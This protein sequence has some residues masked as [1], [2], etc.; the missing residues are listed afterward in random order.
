MT[1]TH[2]SSG[3]V[4]RVNPGRTG[5]PLIDTDEL[6]HRVSALDVARLLS[7]GEGRP[8]SGWDVLRCP[9]PNHEDRHPSF[10]VSTRTAKF[11]CRSCGLE[12]SGPFDLVMAVNRCDFMEAVRWVADRFGSRE[13]AG[14]HVPRRAEAKREEPKDRPVTESFDAAERHPDQFKHG[15]QFRA[16][17]AK[18]R[19]WSDD[20]S[21][22]SAIDHFKIELVN[23]PRGGLRYRFPF[24]KDGVSVYWQ[25]RSIRDDTRPKWTG[26]TG[27][28]P[29]PFNV[30][31]LDYGDTLLLVEGL[32][33]VITAWHLKFTR[34]I[35]GVPGV[36]SVGKARWLAGLKAYAI[37]A[38]HPIAVIAD[39]DPA[40]LTLREKLDDELGDLVR[41][42]YVPEDYGDLTDWW[43]DVGHRDQDERDRMV[44]ALKEA[45]EGDVCL[46]KTS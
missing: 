27:T 20:Y 39:N 14:S 18:D 46:P 11:E 1:K 4:P 19:C 2:S 16:K 29:V 25:D 34:T 17:L 23:D 31:S 7:E 41:H 9:M 21:G 8:I 30:D 6:R 36:Q 37:E 26:P 32:P 22:T 33:D 10:Q 3:V 24:L 43:V 45:S 13:Q 38:G 15:G 44:H 35:I 28:V 42:V 5:T 12:G 40:G